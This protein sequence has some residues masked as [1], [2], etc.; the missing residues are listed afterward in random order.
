M[1]GMVS[2]QFHFLLFTAAVPMELIY[3][4][5]ILIMKTG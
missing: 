5:A 2:G 3:D 1:A 4:P